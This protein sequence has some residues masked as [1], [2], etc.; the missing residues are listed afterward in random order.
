M[1]RPR[2]LRNHTDE[3]SLLCVFRFVWYRHIEANSPR[4]CVNPLLYNNKMSITVSVMAYENLRAV[5]S[6][7]GL[8]RS[9]NIY[10]RK[11]ERKSQNGFGRRV[12]IA[13][14]VFS[15]SSQESYGIL[16]V[17]VE[18]LSVFSVMSLLGNNSTETRSYCLVPCCTRRF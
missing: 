15:F 7:S 2:V 8:Y 6:N 14:L 1:V 5:K 13:H 18:Q 17:V 10:K 11:K 4:R 16:Y 12:K 9:V 3:T